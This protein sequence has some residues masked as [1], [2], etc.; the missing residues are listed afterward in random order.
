MAIDITI[1]DTAADHIK[2]A[3]TNA[4]G[5]SV[6]G[7]RLH[8]KKAGCSGYEYVVEYAYDLGP[9]DSEISKNGACL[10]V[11]REIYQKFLVGTVV[12]FRQEGLNEGLVFDNPN[13]VG[14]CGCGESFALKE[15]GVE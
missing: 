11:D 1:T 15:K 8:V 14:Q 9:L 5:D 3:M 13:V 7:V 2:E 4:Q 6:K 10:V 12:D